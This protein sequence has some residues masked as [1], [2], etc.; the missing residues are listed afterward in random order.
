[1]LRE[2]VTELQDAADRGREA[3]AALE[4]KNRDLAFVEAEVAAI[5]GEF[6]VSGS[7]YCGL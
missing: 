6:A 4:A 2:E 3:E 7:Y 1:M 5:K